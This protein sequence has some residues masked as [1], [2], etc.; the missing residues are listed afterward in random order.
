MYISDKMNVSKEVQ[1]AIKEG[2]LVIGIDSVVKNLKRGELKSVIYSK[3]CRQDLLENLTYYQKNFKIDMKKFN[4]NSKLLG[5][6]CGKP[7]NIM[8]LGIRK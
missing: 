3:N 2:K 7:F 8:V 4:G 5:E 6:I 1:N